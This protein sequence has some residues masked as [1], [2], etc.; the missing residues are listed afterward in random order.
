MSKMFK[1]AVEVHIEQLKN[2][3]TG[4]DPRHVE[5]ELKSARALL[6]QTTDARLRSALEKRV[7]TLES[8]RSNANGAED[9]KKI[10]SAIQNVYS[11]IR[12]RPEYN[13]VRKKR[14]EGKRAKSARG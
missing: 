5:D 1:D 11:L 2:K 4:A 6:A 3:I 14:G 13:V 12:N 9:Y 7:S 10:L 8:H